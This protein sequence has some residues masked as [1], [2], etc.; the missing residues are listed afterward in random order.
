MFNE[1]NIQELIVIV[2]LSL[3]LLVLL[4][5]LFNFDWLNDAIIQFH[6]GIEKKHSK[7]K[8]G[9]LR[10]TL[11]FFKYPGEIPQGMKHDGWKSGFTLLSLTFSTIV[12]GGTIAAIGMIV[13]YVVLAIVSIIIVII[14]IVVVIAIIGAILSAS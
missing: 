13:Y 6:N 11:A 12:I 1:Y 9:L 10:F 7:T 3:L 4:I 5:A 2:T 14:I 8:S